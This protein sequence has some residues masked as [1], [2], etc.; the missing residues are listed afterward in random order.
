MLSHLGHLMQDHEVIVHLNMILTFLVSHVHID[1]LGLKVGWCGTVDRCVDS[2]MLELFAGIVLIDSGHILSKIV[3]DES[4]IG[5]AVRSESSIC[6]RA[7]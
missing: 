1:P 3:V 2:Q 4:I 6:Q 5:T 7:S